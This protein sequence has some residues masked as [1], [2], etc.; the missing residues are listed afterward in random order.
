LRCRCVSP[1]LREALL[2]LEEALP[3]GGAETTVRLTYWRNDARRRVEIVSD[4][5]FDAEVII[6]AFHR[7][8]REGVW[9]Y[10]ML[11]DV[12]HT[13]GTPTF[14]ELARLRSEEAQGGTHGERPGP[15]VIIATSPTLFRRACAYA[16]L[17]AVN[18]PINVVE[19][20]TE[21]ERW[22]AEQGF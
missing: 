15:L 5:P 10:A 11:S 9:D 8:Q 17:G 13:T 3:R 6:D 20:R 4:G 14:E 7:Q 22:L 1:I 12:R 2:L 19:D 18:R 16:V 21:A